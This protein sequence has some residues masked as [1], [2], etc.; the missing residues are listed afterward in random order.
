MGAAAIPIMAVG[1]GLSAYSQYQEGKASKNY[2]DYLA[3]TS[4]SNAML[5]RTAGEVEAK[6]I[7]AQEMQQVGQIHEQG[8][9]VVG[10]Q[11]AA[12]ASGGAGVGSKTGEQLVSDTLTKVDLDEQALRYNADLRMKNARIGAESQALNEESQAYGY[13]IAGRNAKK[14]GTIGAYTSLLSG[15]GNVAALNYK[16]K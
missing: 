5:A 6:S 11:K 15:A 12:L 9:E 3:G 8:R 2:Y 14:A 4:K 7:G 13:K 1:A 16:V 10:A